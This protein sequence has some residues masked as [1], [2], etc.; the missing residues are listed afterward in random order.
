M[1]EEKG[2]LPLI[3]KLMT[4]GREDADFDK[5]VQDVFGVDKKDLGK[6]LRQKLSEYALR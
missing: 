2:G 4:Y 5:A 1:A 6:F 3:R